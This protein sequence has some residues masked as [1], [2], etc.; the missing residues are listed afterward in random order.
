VRNA[1]A[2]AAAVGVAVILGACAPRLQPLEPEVT[3]PAI[4]DDRLAMADGVELPLRR[5]LPRGP[6]KAV[7]LALHGFNDYSNAFDAPAKTWAEA[8]IATYAYD[9]RGFGATPYRGLWA[10]EERMMGDLAAAARLVRERHPG[11]PFYLL[12]ESMGGALVMASAAAPDPP[13]ADGIILVA[14]AVWGREAQGPLNSLF[15]WLG[16]HTVPWM[17]FGG[18]GLDITPSDNIEMLRALGRDPL[19]IKKARVDTILGLVNLMDMAYAAAPRLTGPMLVLFGSRE[20]VI[21]PRA[22]RTMLERLP[23]GPGGDDASPAARIA[24]YRD[25]YHMLLRDLRADLARGDVRAWIE[26]ASRAL[27]SGADAHAEKIMAMDDD[28]GLTLEA[29]APPRRR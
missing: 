22:A 26:N 7:I 15:L 24:I 4:L 1:G 8:G 23:G 12:G 10:G 14:P 28:D 17:R 27:P 9:Q 6:P 16:A 13:A 3:A 29:S 20:E 21:P 11:A 19:V 2:F 5:W 18:E 25:G